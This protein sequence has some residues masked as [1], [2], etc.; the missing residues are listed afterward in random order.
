MK[1]NIKLSDD[2]LRQ[3]IDGFSLDDSRKSKEPDSYVTTDQGVY[4]FP[5]DKAEILKKEK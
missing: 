1:K 3:I 5:N 2:K 4:Y